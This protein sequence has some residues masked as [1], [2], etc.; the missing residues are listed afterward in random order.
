MVLEFYLFYVLGLGGGHLLSGFGSGVPG[1]GMLSNK[2]SSLIL[3]S[4][5]PAFFSTACITVVFT[6]CSTSNANLFS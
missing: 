3:S 5:T 6:S 1:G 4:N 2:W